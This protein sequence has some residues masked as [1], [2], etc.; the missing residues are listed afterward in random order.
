MI[1]KSQ[2]HVRDKWKRHLGLVGNPSVMRRVPSTSLLSQTSLQDYL[3]RH[4]TVFI[5]P[6][7]GSF[8]NGIMKITRG[9]KHYIVQHEKRVIRVASKDIGKTV[10]RHT[11]NKRYLI[12]RGVDL[13]KLYS[14]PVDFR[15]LVL[16]PEQN[17]IV[18][19]TMGKIASGNHIVTNYNHGGKPIGLESALRIAGYNQVEISRMRLEMSRLSLET[20]KTFNRKYQHC[21]R[22]G[23]DI[24]IDKQKRLWILEVNTN[25][26]YELFRHH[27]DRKLYGRIDRYM[28][29]IKKNQSNH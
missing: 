21:R 3:S 6:V 10:F 1:R 23:I 22:M 2:W 29:H 4:H 26:F 20:A 5:K 11:R 8:G 18:M 13:L 19:G 25:P 28:K 27:S 16:K 14:K 17:W 24:A 9:H 15:V 12:Q 7:N